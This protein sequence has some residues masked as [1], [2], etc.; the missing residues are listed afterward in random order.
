MPIKRR[1]D[2]HQSY[3][4]PMF[5]TA[6]LGKVKI[7]L[8]LQTQLKNLASCVGNLF[9][10]G[11]REMGIFHLGGTKSASVDVRGQQKKLADSYFFE[12]IAIKTDQG[13]IHLYGKKLKKFAEQWMEKSRSHAFTSDEFINGQPPTFQ[14]FIEKK[15]STDTDLK[16]VIRS[17][18]VRYFNDR[19]RQET[20]V[21]IVDGLL[22]QVGLDNQDTSQLH[23][24][25][26]KAKYAFVLGDVVE[27]GKIATK[28]FAT[29]KIKTEKGLIQHS[30]FLR[31]GN[32]K[33]AG[34][35][36]P[37][38]GPDGAVTFLLRSQSG[39][40]RPT[41]KEMAHLLSYLK[42]SK[43]DISTIWVQGTRFP[44]V[45]QFLNKIKFGGSWAMATQRADLWY[46]QTGKDLIKP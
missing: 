21:K 39:H 36:I 27:N 16:Q 6:Y 38:V 7:S 40:Y 42:N 41:Q 10:S 33:A 1:T 26:A 5:N 15:A 9:S 35:L 8:F 25:K 43:Y 13:E 3:I 31:G 11:E 23:P 30:S 17:E 14:Q 46:E 44:L 37:Q 12:T 2:Q 28:L 18:S 22:Y 32:V 24:L 20:E 34:M 19:E 45:N 4:T 29:P